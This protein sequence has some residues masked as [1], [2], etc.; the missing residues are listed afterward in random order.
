MCLIIADF[1]FLSSPGWIFPKDF[2]FFSRDPVDLQAPAI[3][4]TY[5]RFNGFFP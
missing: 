5:G 1:L 2:L 4:A 3:S